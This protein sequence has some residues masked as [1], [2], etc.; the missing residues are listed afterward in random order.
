M[1]TPFPRNPASVLLIQ[2]ELMNLPNGGLF[3]EA[4][5]MGA[6]TNLNG[7]LRMIREQAVSNR[8]YT[9][10]IIGEDLLAKIEEL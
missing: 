6:K 1:T 10:E 4:V 8:G 7:T 2:D 3:T 5:R 9:I